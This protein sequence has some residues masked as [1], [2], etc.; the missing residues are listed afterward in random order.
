MPR[1]RNP[2]R[3]KSYQIWLEHKGDISNRRIAELLG[4]NEKVIAVWK[5]RD[6]W[7]VVQQSKESCT[8]NGV[9]WADI[10]SEYISDI[11]KKPC[12]LE[13]LGKKH[14]IS[15]SQISKYAA[16]H[17]WTNKRK[18][19]ENSVKQKSA[20][21]AAD[22]ISNDIAKVTA[23][24]LRI[25]DKLLA[26]VEKTLENPKEFNTIVE[27]LKTGYGPGEF[28]ERIVTEVVDALNDS[29]LLNVVN[30]FEKLQRAQRQTLRILD[31]RD[32]Q[33]LEI[34][35]AKSTNAPDDETEDDGFIDALKGK[36]SEVWDD[37]VDGVESKSESE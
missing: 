20:E 5:Q 26:V 24:H 1:E 31:E 2:N 21:K 18:S 14:G 32:K 7:N 11:R 25:S 35:K 6:K 17:A 4:E 12:T 15:F 19:Y 3:D 36:V 9:L 34:A 29:K 13:E 37:E 16:E 30:A 8:T 33:S 28:D 27:K 22:I 10:E 23:K